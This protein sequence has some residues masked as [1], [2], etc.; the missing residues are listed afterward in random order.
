MKM[1]KA[2]AAVWEERW[3]A[4]ERGEVSF[5]FVGERRVLIKVNCGSGMGFW[6]ENGGGRRIFEC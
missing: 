2:F 5:M 4:A 3:D 6:A 1:G